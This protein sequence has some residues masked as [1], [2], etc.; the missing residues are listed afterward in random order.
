MLIKYQNLHKYLT[1][2]YLYVIAGPESYISNQVIAVIKKHCATETLT[3]NLESPEDFDKIHVELNSYSLFSA[4]SVM[5]LH[6]H[7]KTLDKS[8]KALFSELKS[9]KLHTIILHVPNIN[10]KLLGNM[11]TADNVIAINAQSLSKIEFITWIRQE[12]KALTI[13]FIPEIPEILQQ[14]TANNM[15]ACAQI[16]TMIDLSF[17]KDTILDSDN[18][19]PYLR[20]QNIY[21]LY[22][23]SNAYIAQ[24]PLHILNILTTLK[25]QQVEPSLILWALST[26]I[27]KLL[28]LTDA[29]EK[30]EDFTASCQKLKIW[31]SQIA[32]YRNKLKSTDKTNI[33][34]QLKICQ[35]IDRK[36]KTNTYDVWQDLERLAVMD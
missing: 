16:M 30:G 12:L 6:Y 15:Q 34:K 13:N 7:K 9:S 26:E 21:P 4:H 1:K 10:L 27:K 22:E 32:T 36:I 33:I 28:E 8:A 17:A 29:T 35:D 11:P 31:N 19:K 5:I 23:L 2:A 20:S 3:I 25:T 24:Q 18:I 14:C